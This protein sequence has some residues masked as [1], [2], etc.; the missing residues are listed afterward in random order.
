MPI[1]RYWLPAYIF[2]HFSSL[3][4]SY[5]WRDIIIVFAALHSYWEF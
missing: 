5:Y 2:L 3:L 1:L 4:A